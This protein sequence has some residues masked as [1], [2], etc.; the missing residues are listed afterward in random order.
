MRLGIRY[1]DTTLP[2]AGPTTD[3]VSVV[4]FA[5]AAAPYAVFGPG[6]F[7][8]NTNTWR[9]DSSNGRHASAFGSV[10]SKFQAGYGASNAVP[11]V[12]GE[13]GA[14]FNL[15]DIASMP[16]YTVCSVSRYTNVDDPRRRKM[17]IRGH[18]NWL[19]G[20]LHRT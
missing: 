3:I 13:K 14:G 16:E 4:K 7:D 15:L 1:M 8:Q 5:A 12:E 18:N 11:S 20:H 19:T 6:G 9:D 2:Y 10:S 17:V